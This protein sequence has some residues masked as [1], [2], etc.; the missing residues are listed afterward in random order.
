MKSNK[1]HH[2]AMQ[3]RNM[4]I[5]FLYFIKVVFV[6]LIITCAGL[7]YY[8]NILSRMMYSIGIGVAEIMGECGMTLSHVSIAGQVNVSTVDLLKTLNA[9]SN[10]PIFLIDIQNARSE[11]LKNPW[12]KNAIVQRKLPHT[13]ALNIAERTPIALWQN[14]KILRVIDDDGEVIDSVQ[15]ENFTHLLHI[16]GADANVYAKILLDDM[17][18]DPSLSSRVI[19]ATRFGERRWNLG[20]Q[21]GITVKM[22]QQNFQDAWQYL[23]KLHNANALFGK[24]YKVI[25]LRNQERY[26]FEKSIS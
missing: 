8:T 15:P 22:P 19:S 11:L 1:N 14:N 9:D 26:F 16:I 7:V 2:E 12:V 18:N 6:L 10:T 5:K 17:K 21:G 25:D 20:L 4:R 24:G 23:V 13:I 3:Q